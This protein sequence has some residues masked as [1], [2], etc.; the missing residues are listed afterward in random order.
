MCISRFVKQWGH[1]HRLVTYKSQNDPH[2]VVEEAPQMR[3]I[4]PTLVGPLQDPNFILIMDWM[5]V[6]FQN[7]SKGTIKN[8]VNHSCKQI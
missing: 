4:V 2:V 6:K 5:S 3:T 1:V 8:L 7:T